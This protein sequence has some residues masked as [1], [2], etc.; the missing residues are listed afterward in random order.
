MPKRNVSFPSKLATNIST[1]YGLQDKKD[2]KNV[3]KHPNGPNGVNFLL[4][5]KNV[6]SI[7]ED[8]Q[9]STKTSVHIQNS[10]KKP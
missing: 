4:H 2:S 3:L 5:Y 9:T 1:H 8:K 10:V 6:I 7:P